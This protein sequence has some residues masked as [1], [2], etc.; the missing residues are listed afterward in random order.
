MRKLSKTMT[1]SQFE[2]GYWYAVELKEFAESIGIPSANKLRK[3][4]LEKAIIAFLKTG[5]IRVPT[6]RALTKSGV[7]DVAKGLS[8]DLP[9]ENYTSNKE[10]KDFIVRE[11]QGIVPGLKERS[12]VRYR[13]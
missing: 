4:E 7:R 5:R 13:L 11:A 8:L 3:D 12:G 9:V 6:Q 1:V 2:N 10:T